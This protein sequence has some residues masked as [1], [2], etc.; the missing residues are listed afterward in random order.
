M[1]YGNVEL[2]NVAELVDLDGLLR[3]QRLPESLRL[4]LNPGAQQRAMRPINTEI[5]FVAIRIPG[6]GDAFVRRICR[7]GGVLGRFPESPA[8]LSDP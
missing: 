8:L 1:I 3:I 7:C 6:A 5:R 4:K 2:H